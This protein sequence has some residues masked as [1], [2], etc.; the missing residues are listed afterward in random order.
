VFWGVWGREEFDFCGGFY[1]FL[2]RTDFF[3]SKK[4]EIN[5]TIC[6]FWGY[7]QEYYGA[8]GDQIVGLENSMG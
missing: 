5:E 2:I 1:F 7:K 8:Y 3:N 4:D 6:E